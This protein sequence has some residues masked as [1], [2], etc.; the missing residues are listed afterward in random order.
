M[1][2]YVIPA[3]HRACISCVC[4][5][6]SNS[7]QRSAVESAAG[8]IAVCDCFVRATWPHWFVFYSPVKLAG[9]FSPVHSPFFML[10]KTAMQVSLGWPVFLRPAHGS[11]R[12][13][14]DQQPQRPPAATIQ[15]PADDF[16][17]AFV[18]PQV[19]RLPGG[20]LARDFPH[21]CQAPVPGAFELLDPLPRVFL[22]SFVAAF[23]AVEPPGFVLGRVLYVAAFVALLA[24]CIAN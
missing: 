20:S 7:D 2:D 11:L 6:F 13:G 19:Y 9:F 14:P 23:V 4:S 18:T 1:R 12:P 24:T 3:G 5:T 8:S 16:A 17:N 10:F 22:E 15:K 21:N